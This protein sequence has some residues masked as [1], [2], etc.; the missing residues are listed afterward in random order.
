VS[1]GRPLRVLLIEDSDDDAQ[2]ILRELRRGGFAPTA[3]RVDD[4]AS[5]RAALAEP[6]DV[7]LCDYSLPGFGAL[8]AFAIAGEGGRDVPFLLVSGTIGEEAA[9]EAMRAGVHDF[10][11]KD[12]LAR[13]VPAISREL[14]EASH[15]ASLRRAEAALLRAEKLRALGQM[16]A[17]IAHDF[18]NL[19]NPLGL[20]LEI[21][22]RALRKANVERPDAIAVM[23]DI[24][25]RGAETIDRLRTFSRLDPEPVAEHIDL[26]AAAREAVE[27]VRPRLEAHPAISLHTDLAETGTVRGHTADAIGAIVNLLVNAADACGDRGTIAVRTGGDERAAWVEVADDGPG[28]TP[29]VEV[30]VFEPFFS[31]K[32]EQGTGLGLANVFATVQRHGGEIQLDTAPGRGARF[33]MT[34]PR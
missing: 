9:V 11:L 15:R 29:D 27:L 14:T 16:A 26:A 25:R 28:M 23:R 19:L 31:T 21:V 12:R 1:D 4:A 8:Q 18:K 17:G 10:V 22:D 6:W 5:L 3:R 2:M 32:G 33:T 13:L 30:R 34:F 7:I 24:I 20:H